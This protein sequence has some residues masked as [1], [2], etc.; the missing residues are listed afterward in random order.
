[1]LASWESHEFAGSFMQKSRKGPHQSHNA[2]E[3]TEAS[4]LSSSAG[5]GLDF[6]IMLCFL[7]SFELGSF[8]A[9][10]PSYVTEG[11]PAFGPFLSHQYLEEQEGHVE[12]TGSLVTCVLG[13][14]L[15]PRI[16]AFKC[17]YEMQS[18]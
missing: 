8:P 7:Q 3:E 13:P 11:G 14:W 2:D 12:G 17:H 4:R 9:S 10:F 18:I 5:A 6:S 16:C 15:D 1:M